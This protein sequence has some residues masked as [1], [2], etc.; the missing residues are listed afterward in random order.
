MVLGLVMT[1]NFLK[2]LLLFMLM[3]AGAFAA[4]TPPPG[5]NG[6]YII[7]NNG[8]WG[9][10]SSSAVQ[11]FLGASDTSTN[12][13]VMGDPTTGL[14]SS[15]AGNISFS[16]SG[17]LEGYFS[18]SGLTLTTP[19]AVSSG[20]TGQ[21]SVP[22]VSGSAIYNNGG[23]ALGGITTGT[24][25]G[26]GATVLQFFQAANLLY[27]ITQG[28]DIDPRYY[29][30][31]CNTKSF[32]GNYG[33]NT[34][35]TVSGSPVISIGG[36]TFQNCTAGVGNNCDVGRV[37]SVFAPCNPGPTTY[38]A[39]VN[40]GTNQATLGENM[41]CTTTGS[42]NMAAVIGG[43]P[44]DFAT[45]SLAADDT[46]AIHEASTLS[47]IYHGGRV[48]LPT[49]CLVG[50]NGPT[51]TNPAGP[52]VMANNS[53]LVGNNG[54][55]NYGTISGGAGSTTGSVTTLFI[56]SD[57][58]TDDTAMGISINSS[59]EVRLRDFTIQCSTFPYL[60]YP[61][62]NL[63]AIGHTA[64][65]GIDPENLIMDHISF[66]LC[67]VGFGI[68]FGWNQPVT[69][70]AGISGNAMTVS[71]ITSDNFLAPSGGISGATDWLAVGRTITGIGVTAGT[72]ITGA[73]PQGGA[74]AYTVSPSQTVS[75]GT[76]MTAGAVG[77]FTGG[78]SR[79]LEFASNGIGMNGDL[80]DWADE[81]SVFTGNF[82][83]GA[84]VGPKQGSAGNAANRFSN[85]RFEENNGSGYSNGAA[86]ECDGCSNI[87]FTGEQFQFNGG[88]AIGTV[89]TWSDVLVTGGMMEGNGAKYSASGSKGQI[90][91][92]GTGT[93]FVL[94][95]VQ[96]LD[97][98][99]SG[100]CATAT[101]IFANLSGSS[102][103]YIVVENGDIRHGYSSAIWNGAMPT[104]YKQDSYGEPHIDTTQS[105]INIGTTGLIGIGT[106]AEVNA[107]GVNGAVAIG[108]GYVGAD[109]A[110]TNG[111][112]V[113]GA[114]GVGT[115]S[116][117]TGVALDL[118][119][120]TNSLL[121]PTGTSGARPTGIAGMVRYNTT[122]PSVEAY[123]NGEWNPLGSGAVPLAMSG[124][125]LSNDV[126]T[127]NTIFDIAAGGA[128]SDD[129]TTFMTLPN[130]YSKTT[131]SWVV[132]AG[133]GCLDAGSI[134]AS[135][136]YYV[137]LIERTDT[138]I[139]DVL[140]SA[141]IT[142]PTYPTNYTVKRLVGFLETDGS[143][144][145]LSF[146]QTGK[147]YSWTIPT[148]DL[149]AITIGTTALSETLNVPPG[150]N[151][152]PYGSYTMS[153]TGQAILWSSP[154]STP[155]SPTTTNPFT[156]APGFTA[157]EIGTTGLVTT[158]LPVVTTNTSSQIAVQATAAS[159]TL[160]EITQGYIAD[161]SQPVPLNPIVNISFLT[162]TL[163]ANVTFSRASI[164]WFF[165]SSGNLVS[166]ATNVPRFDYG[167]PGSSTLVGLLTEPTRTNYVISSRDLTQVA[168]WTA[169]SVTVSLNQTGIDGTSN[170]ASSLTATS[171]NGTV[172]QF[173]T[174]AS[175]SV[176]TSMYMKRITG[177]GTISI[178]QDGVTYNNQSL[179][180]SWQRFSIAPASLANPEVCIELST[181][182]DEIAVDVV[183]LENAPSHA[184]VTSPIVTTTSGIVTRSTDVVTIASLPW[185]NV[186]GG[187]YVYEFE[188]ANANAASGNDFSFNG[189]YPI[190]VNNNNLTIA[191][192]G[193][194]SFGSH[195]NADIFAGMSYNSPG[196]VFT[197]VFNG[198]SKGTGS[199]L[200]AAPTSIVFGGGLYSWARS[201]KYYPY[202]VS[203]TTLETLAP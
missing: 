155:G 12:P 100:D 148:I 169:T 77:S 14:Y 36:Y 176:A 142:S 104:H 81:G 174:L 167:T 178:A 6:Q 16:S 28:M 50:A 172:C 24:V 47:A 189:I 124:L 160:S 1:K 27:Q 30:A 5:T 83:F 177:T 90:G 33:S 192:S 201:F 141:S 65:T 184:F 98:C 128:T 126:V 199:A 96:I 43:Y 113:Q 20:G 139:V 121:I 46:A 56:A 13:L 58:M 37:I 103:D 188:Q 166:A 196:G 68:P 118:G 2:T 187:T 137:F 41:A 173:I 75:G 202:P 146:T 171:T 60:G 38:I 143:S 73:P 18:S 105:T 164:G 87:Q 67:P 127:P 125:G 195:L 76:P 40:T 132:G 119:T 190:N 145:V 183:Q 168:D 17:T 144:H 42:G 203:T 191:G 3:S 156:A 185:Y 193:N 29:G 114:V 182:G 123:Y 147:N 120:N 34:L 108:A 49:N 133:N 45:P 63:A 9:A 22:G 194:I 115:T 31:A 57:G 52:L 186:N 138:N 140:C 88:W 198:V 112:L 92:G 106:T 10:V 89:N 80:S 8:Q 161:L 15:V 97:S 66:N 32:N 71:A 117:Q 150:V 85:G 59:H 35:T 102:I 84:Y 61:G 55:N 70:T 122:I 93:D 69:F 23:T 4:S 21:T 39:S 74:G 157:L 72:V 101:N 91:L 175:S 179:S 135:T 134:A 51:L 11:A 180:G 181:S 79:F 25:G 109:V 26:I 7:N 95:G 53:E 99:F 64:A 152:V 107:F 131:G 136:W 154:S 149:N 94:S 111:L 197:T 158:N 200:A 153:N 151:V 129:N 162:G 82:S 170:T 44:T 159:T 62:L 54:G 110:P 48:K 86:F 78:S 130:Q 19:L 165:N 163:P 116:P